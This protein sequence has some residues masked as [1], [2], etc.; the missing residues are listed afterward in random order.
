MKIRK[1]YLKGLITRMIPTL[2]HV[3]QSGTRF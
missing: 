3:C 1:E 2:V